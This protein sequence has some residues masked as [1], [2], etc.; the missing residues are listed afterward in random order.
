MTR[1]T[2][3]RIAK[4]AGELKLHKIA[5]NKKIIISAIISWRYFWGGAK[6]RK[7]C[8]SVFSC[9]YENECFFVFNKLKKMVKDKKLKNVEK[10][11]AQK[12]VEILNSAHKT[13][14]NS[15]G[16]RFKTHRFRVSNP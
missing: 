12:N 7:K 6:N 5:N 11:I 1:G 10:H 8:R 13:G 9:Y 16:L 4:G 14:F 15:L 3:K 2:G